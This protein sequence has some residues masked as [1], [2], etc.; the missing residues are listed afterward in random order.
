MKIYV[1]LK[2]KRE[3]DDKEKIDS[4]KEKKK[5]SAISIATLVVNALSF[6][7]AL[8]A[9]LK[10]GTIKDLVKGIKNHESTITADELWE[11]DIYK[12]RLGCSST[13]VEELID[14]PLY[15]NNIDFHGDKYTEAYYI[16]SCCSLECIYDDSDSL[17]GL[18]V[19]GNDKK[20]NPENYRV[21]FSLY[22]YSINEVEEKYLE[23]GINSYILCKSSNTNRLDQNSYYIECNLQHSDGATPLYFVGYGVC[24]IGGLESADTF[25]DESNKMTNYDYE[26]EN[27]YDYQVVYHDES[28][29]DEIRN[30]PINTFFI[31][32]E[33]SN[34]IEFLHR[35]V[36][37]YGC[38]CMSRDDYANYQDSYTECISE[39]RKNL[40]IDE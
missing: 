38:Y 9:F 25:Y 20:F 23:N 34:D 22:D 13:Y 5:S 35:F 18:V 29:R 17:V 27:Q 1:K 8:L 11:N 28:K 39:F 31:V 16:N 21:G 30:L 15:T 37:P 7:L 6:F 32:K 4:V 12:I 26:K 2:D 10:L 33:I 14:T 19:V 3:L 24:D 36:V 40:H